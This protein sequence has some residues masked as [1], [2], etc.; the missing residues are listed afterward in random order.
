MCQILVI[1]S[2]LI[3][4]N[5][6]ERRKMARFIGVSLWLYFREWHKVPEDE[7]VK[8]EVQVDEAETSLKLVKMITY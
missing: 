7:G 2:K 3:F 8:H 1:V 4:L 6:N 5:M